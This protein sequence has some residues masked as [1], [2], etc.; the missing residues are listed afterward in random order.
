MLGF[1]FVAPLEHFPEVQG[2]DG[3]R[4]RGQG[5]TLYAADLTV[6]ETARGRGVGR[7]AP[8]ALNPH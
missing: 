3:D 6:S 7:A 5:N 8:P 2:P 4:F 1:I